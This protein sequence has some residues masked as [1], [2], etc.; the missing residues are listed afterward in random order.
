MQSAI[1]FAKVPPMKANPPGKRGEAFFR[2]RTAL[3]RAAVS[4]LVAAS[5]YFAGP[6]FLRTVRMPHPPIVD[7]FQDWASATN[8]RL[9]R[10][11]YLPQ[12]VNL[13][14]LLG[15][16]PDR[17]APPMVR[18]N[19]HPPTSV[20]F[21]LPIGWLTYPEALHVWTLVSL[22][23]LACAIGMLARGVGARWSACSLAILVA[24]LL[25]FP[26]LWSH[27][28]QRQWTIP[29]LFLLVLCWRL[30]QGGRSAAAGAVLAAAS[31]IKLFPALLLVLLV[32]R[33]K[34]A[35]V[36]AWAIASAAIVLTAGLLFGFETYQTFAF[37]I[38]PEVRRFEGTAANFSLPAFWKKILDPDAKDA[39]V[40]LIPFA[41]RPDLAA[42][43]LRAS[44]AAVAAITAYVLGRT[45][46]G[47]L[48]LGF[49]ALTVAML[50]INPVTWDHSLLLAILPWTIAWAGARG[51]VERAFLAI[52][53]AGLAAP[54][55]V[56]DMYAK[57]LHKDPVL[58]LN[59]R[60]LWTTGPWEIVTTLA[61]PTYALLAL[62]VILAWQA[63][64]RSEV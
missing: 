8:F 7:L 17:F 51:I 43:G 62:L 2:P 37:E 3:G 21:A 54:V 10:P 59:G 50:L 41:R 47:P 28:V 15:A 38:V 49:A 13:E 27:L 26:P 20:L 40:R 44:F 1:F 31:T 45:R 6:I 18:V 55:T 60:P 34:W 4:A 57:Q 63:S 16:R 30:L 5:L 19:G 14:Q 35:G 23:L 36:A 12:H 52:L 25:A 42:W 33:R 46:A 56:I 22:V 32:A 39:A 9:G 11:I 64:R 24:V 48:D 61:I 58:A 53:L 29:I